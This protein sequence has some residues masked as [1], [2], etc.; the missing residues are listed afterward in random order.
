MELL[1]RLSDAIKN[2]RMVHLEQVD[3]EIDEIIDRIVNVIKEK[4]TNG[5]RLFFIGNG[6]SAAIA[7]HMTADFMKN[8][9]ITTVSMYDPAMLTCLGNDYGY[10]YVFSKQLEMHMNE[11]DFLIAVSSS[12][13]SK[14]IIN[15]IEVAH[16]RKAEVLSLTG[17]KPDN[18]ARAVAD[19]SIYVPVEE[20]GIVESVHNLILQEIVD[21]M[22]A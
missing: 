21:R 12:G 16:N 20:Y 19:Y 8:G 17:F 11:N 3:R 6:G 5:G 13:N 22:N 4:Q 18:K 9:G 1:T 7:V 2:T 15:A 14:N 10:E